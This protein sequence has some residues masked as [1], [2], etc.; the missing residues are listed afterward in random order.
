ML[1]IS[2]DLQQTLDTAK[3]PVTEVYY[4]HQLNTYNLAVVNDS[5]LEGDM[6][7]WNEAEGRK[8]PDKIASCLLKYTDSLPLLVNRLIAWS[9][10]CGGQNKNH[11][12]QILWMHLVMSGQLKTIQH[13]LSGGGTHINVM[14]SLLW[15]LAQKA[16][17]RLHRDHDLYH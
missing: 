11:Q 12:L 9:D 15:P 7:A 6:F 2:F 5:T 10:G 3:L 13:K 4:L 1:C 16:L 17:H 8:G 14:R